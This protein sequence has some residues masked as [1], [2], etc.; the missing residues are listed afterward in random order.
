MRRIYTAR[1]GFHETVATPCAINRRKMIARQLE[2]GS[3]WVVAVFASVALVRSA[4]ADEKLAKVTIESDPAG[5]TVAIDGGAQPTRTPLT[6]SLARGRHVVTVSAPDRQLERRA[7]EAAG[8]P[9]TLSFALIRVP[10]ESEPGKHG[11][12]S[13]RKQL[14][15]ELTARARSAHLRDA[16]LAL[17]SGAV[18]WTLAGV[19]FD[20][21]ETALA[22][23]GAAA[24]AEVAGV[25]KA[26]AGVRFVVIG[27]TNDAP[28]KSDLA[29]DNTELSIAHAVA[30][31]RALIGAG[32]PAEDVSADGRGDIDPIASNA[33]TDGKRK[34]L[35]I[36]IVIV[37]KTS[38]VAVGDDKPKPKALTADAF[39][40][41]VSAIAERTHACY[42]GTQANVVVKM[43]IAPSGQVTKLVVAAPFA[44]K[45]E[46]DCIAGIIKSVTFAAWDGAPQTFSSSF[47]LSD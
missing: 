16:K 28:F 6:V 5:A 29:R 37:S 27:H 8:A 18:T 35:R 33:S 32:I 24:V 44:G 36:E 42:K 13:E 22:R 46:G 26:Q 30:V 20:P 7:V 1:I 11:D 14:L 31:A 47:L 34:N 9:V 10:S 38:N 23:D 21:S 12:D 45:P 39:K 15:D 4:A 17:R 40:Q 19:G 25:L 41:V 2:R 3:A 43:T